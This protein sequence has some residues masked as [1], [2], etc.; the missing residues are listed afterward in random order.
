MNPNFVIM[1]LPGSG[2]TTFLAALWHI[3][4][5]NETKCRLKVDR[6][7]GSLSYLNKI[8]KAWRTFEPV[9]RTSQ[10][11]DADV[12]MYL[13][14]CE[15]GSKGT[16]FFPDIAGERFSDQAEV[17]RGR[18][19]FIANTESC[20]SILLFI[21]AN[22]E[23]DYL[24]IIELNDQMPPDSEEPNEAPAE[25]ATASAPVDDGKQPPKPQPVPEFEPK[26]VPVQVKIVQLLSDF[27]R[28]PFEVRPRR[29]AVILSAWD[30]VATHTPAM[31]PERWLSGNMSLLD[32]FL[33]TNDGVFETRIYGVSAQGVDLEDAA[34]VERAKKLRASE[35]ILIVD[36]AERGHDI[37]TPLVRLMTDG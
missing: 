34:A 8:A 1:G 36:G 13:V 11:G 6:L 28:A 3:M 33:K 19:T 30:V 21:N 10:T 7:E 23:Q 27:L 20:D 2:K 5:A 17:R 32:Q 29:L 26:K 12:T 31:S 24:S 16:A 4:E 37:T 25:Q 14:D 9:E 15:N 18:R 22:A 35:R